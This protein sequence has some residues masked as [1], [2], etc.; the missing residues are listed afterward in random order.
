MRATKGQ[1]WLSFERR[2]AELARHKR[3]FLCIQRTAS[4]A[5][6]FLYNTRLHSRLTSMHFPLV[7]AKISF[8]LKVFSAVSER[9]S[10]ITMHATVD[11]G[12]AVCVVNDVHGYAE[13]LK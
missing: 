3:S 5:P 11:S 13:L 9:L 12:V 8:D 4:G 2:V 7:C 1:A 10:G 6:S